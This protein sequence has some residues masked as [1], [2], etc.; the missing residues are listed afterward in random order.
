MVEEASALAAGD[1]SLYHGLS[2]ILLALHEANRHFGEDQYRHA[3]ERTADA[4]TAGVEQVDDC[5]LYFG[6]AGVAVALRA[7]GRDRGRRPGV[8][9]G[10]GAL[11]RRALERHVRA[12]RR[13]RRDRARRAG[14]RRR[15][16]RGPRR[17]ALPA[18]RRADPGGVN[19]EVRQH[20]AGSTTSR[21]ARSGS[22]TRSPPSERPPTAPTSTALALAGAADVV[23]PQRRRPG[24]FLVPHSDPQHRP[25][26]IERYSYG[27]CHGPAGDAQVFRLLRAVTGDPAWPALGRPLLAHRHPSG[28][29]RR[30]RPGFWDNNGR[31]C[32]TAGVLALACDRYAE[33]AAASTSRRARRRPRRPRDGRRGRRPLVQRRAPG[34]RPATSRRAPDWAMGNAGIVR[35]LLRYARLR[36]SATT[37]YAVQW[38]DH[39]SVIN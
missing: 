11:R 14:L 29:P 28:L 5:S 10:T 3:L 37:T 4:L 6:L 25:E 22:R 17:R 16:A 33:R 34:R 23:S 18:H 19:W 24:G 12:A 31:C 38:P 32:G 8:D 26:L 30:I 15:R 9:T 2:G 20:A 27:W 1:H 39:P 35:E 13:Q 36:D 7:S 21:T